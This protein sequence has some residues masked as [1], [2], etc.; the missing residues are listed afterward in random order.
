MAKIR[1]KAI[2]NFFEKNF[3]IKTEIYLTTKPMLAPA[4][5]KISNGRIEIVI[6]G[7]ICKNEY[8]VLVACCHEIT[9]LFHSKHNQKFKHTLL[10]ILKHAC[11]HLKLDYTKAYNTLQEL[12]NLANI[13]YQEY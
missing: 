10:N 7:N 2:K 3:N 1:F 8:Q 9:H 6:N 5:S 12:D 13:T 11:K 4:V